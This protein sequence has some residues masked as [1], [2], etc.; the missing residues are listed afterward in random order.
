MTGAIVARPGA[1]AQRFLCDADNGHL[2]WSTLLPRH[3]PTNRCTLD[4]RRWGGNNWP[5]RN[6]TANQPDMAV[7]ATVLDGG[8]HAVSRKRVRSWGWR[9]VLCRS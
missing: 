6:W 3:P 1:E 8:S 2:F 9:T 5:A 4:G 7:G